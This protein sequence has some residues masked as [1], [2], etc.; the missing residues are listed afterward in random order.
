MFINLDLLRIVRAT[1]IGLV[2]ILA[3]KRICKEFLQKEVTGETI[4][5]E[6]KQILEDTN[7]R[8]EM[9]R[10]IKAVKASLGDGN[11]GKN[12]STAILKLIRESALL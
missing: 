2:N 8:E 7:Y 3:G 6:A 12:A 4:F 1:D 11:A 10:Q 5:A 9:T